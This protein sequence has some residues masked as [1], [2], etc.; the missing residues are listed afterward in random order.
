MDFDLLH[1]KQI[2]WLQIRAKYI[3]FSEKSAFKNLLVIFKDVVV[4]VDWFF[5]PMNITCF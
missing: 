1:M 2:N 4:E 5:F 3:G